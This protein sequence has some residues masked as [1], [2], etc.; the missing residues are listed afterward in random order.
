MVLLLEEKTA[1]ITHICSEN[2]LLKQANNHAANAIMRSS[3]ASSPHSQ[4]ASV[5]KVAQGLWM[6]EEALLKQEKAH[7]K[8]QQEQQALL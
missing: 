2:E 5:D 4:S 3:A 7:A 1:T 8:Q 6:L